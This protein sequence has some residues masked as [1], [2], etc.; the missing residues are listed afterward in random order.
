[1]DHRCKRLS[2]VIDRNDFSASTNELIRIDEMDT[3]PIID[4]Q[5]IDENFGFAGWF[6][7]S[8]IDKLKMLLGID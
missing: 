5:S 1:M 6:A 2:Y 4:R 8:Q 7:V 3:A